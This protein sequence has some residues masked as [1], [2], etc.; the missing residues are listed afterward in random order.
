M[1]ATQAVRSTDAKPQLSSAAT[2]WR[3]PLYGSN[4][5]RVGRIERVMIE[6]VSGKIAYALMRFGSFMG[7]GEG[8]YP[9]PKCILMPLKVSTY[10]TYVTVTVRLAAPT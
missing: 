3:A 2:R 1:T 9:P 5:E 4:G 10:V 7:F 8:Y 6:K